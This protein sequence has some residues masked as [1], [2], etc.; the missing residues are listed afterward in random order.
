MIAICSCSTYHQHTDSVYTINIFSEFTCLLQFFICYVS[1]ISRHEEVWNMT[2]HFGRWRLKLLPQMSHKDSALMLFLPSVYL[3]MSQHVTTYKDEMVWPLLILLPA[4]TYIICLITAIWLLD[5]S[6][7]DYD[8]SYIIIQLT[9]H[10]YQ[11]HVSC[12]WGS[13]RSSFITLIPSPWS[14]NPQY[15]LKVCLLCRQAHSKQ[16]LGPPRNSGRHHCTYWEIWTTINGQQTDPGL[17]LQLNRLGFT[18]TYST[19][20]SMVEERYALKASKV[21]ITHCSKKK[22]Q[23]YVD[24]FLSIYFSAYVE[25]LQSE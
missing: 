5:F 1:K 18:L 17:N 6:K 22:R 10:L 19:N 11:S 8:S 4:T 2:R 24:T 20:K 9:Q 15:L 25:R 23:T 21:S 7:D 3:W 13:G 14:M 16:L 12:S